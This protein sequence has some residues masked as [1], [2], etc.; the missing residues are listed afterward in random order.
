V[1]S[2]ASAKIS[3]VPFFSVHLLFY[4]YFFPFCRASG[5]SLPEEEAQGKREIQVKGYAR[6]PFWALTP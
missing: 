1:L 2:E 4:F 3:L 5:A 6:R